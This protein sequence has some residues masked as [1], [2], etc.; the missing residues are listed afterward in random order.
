MGEVNPRSVT[1]VTTPHSYLVLHYWSFICSPCCFWLLLWIIK[2][3]EVPLS[4]FP[5]PWGIISAF[6]PNLLLQGVCGRYFLVGLHG[7]QAVISAKLCLPQLC[8][9][10]LL[11]SLHE[12]TLLH[13]I[14]SATGVVWGC[15]KV[16]VGIIAVSVQLQRH[17][18]HPAPGT[19]QPH[20][21]G[22]PQAQ[23][24]EPGWRTA[25]PTTLKPGF[26]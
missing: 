16:T 12:V 21:E 15:L 8:L 2:D 11:I 1:S 26:V 6:R 18:G 14:I 4:L 23:G 24:R 25:E 7:L 20:P 22:F 13:N 5:I 9:C 19:A 3:R 17:Q 10:I